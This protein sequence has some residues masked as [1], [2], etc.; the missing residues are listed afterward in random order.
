M[1]TEARVGG[2][3]AR[4]EALTGGNHGATIPQP[5]V[6]PAGKANVTT[7]CSQPSEFTVAGV[8]PPQEDSQLLV[9]VMASRTPPAGLRVADLCTGSGVVAIAA[10]ARGAASVSAFDLCSKAVRFARA[11]AVA[12]GVDVDVHLGHWSRAAEF[13]PFDLV[14]S[15]PPYVPAPEDG[16]DEP[17]S[18]LAGPPTA[19]DAGPDGRMVLDPMC[20]WAP[21]LLAPNGRM[22]LVHSE[23]SGI[24]RTVA[25]LRAKGLR[26]EV[27]TSQRIPFGP[28][29]AARAAWLERTGQLEAGRRYERIAVIEAVKR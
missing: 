21:D 16:D 26:S 5:P 22:L 19:Y 18:Q 9:D 13:R 23:F 10:A 27:V 7:A 24:E 29:M 14:V 28:V 6:G 12:S 8:Y 4:F 17:I 2:V 20:E 15:N 3:I 11:N 25:A 1:P